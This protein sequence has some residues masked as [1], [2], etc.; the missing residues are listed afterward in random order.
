[1]K[2]IKALH[3]KLVNKKIPHI[4]TFLEGNTVT[5]IISGQ[6]EHRKGMLEAILIDK[7]WKEQS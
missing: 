5:V 3:K 1:M 7:N 4:I 2:E 6:L